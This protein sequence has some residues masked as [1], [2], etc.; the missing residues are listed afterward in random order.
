MVDSLKDLSP[1]FFQNIESVAA[2]QS[3]AVPD[4][5]S[6]IQHRFLVTSN[7]RG[8]GKTSLAANL[9]VTLS[10]REVNVGLMDLD[11]HGKDILQMLGLKGSYEISKDNR[12]IPKP[13]SGYLKVFSIKTIIKDAGQNRMLADLGARVIRQF[14]TDIDWGKLDYLIVN[15]PSG[16]GDEP[17]A[18]SKVIRGA[19]VI[20]VST[21]EKEPLPQ[22]NELIKFYQTA[23]IP[24]LGVIEN[25]SGYIC[26]DCCRTGQSTLRESIIMDIDYLGRIPIDPHMADSTLSDQSFLKKYPNSEAT[27][28]YEIIVDKL[29]KD[30]RS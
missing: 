10:K 6:L 18:V 14:I 19:K 26:K 30:D 9:A 7:K 28:G 29:I 3:Q 22:I 17:L 20:F 12:F 24:I 16:T 2:R 25:M 1:R 11:F 23:Q 27:H 8:V 13:Y 15:S 5:I 21:P 4:S